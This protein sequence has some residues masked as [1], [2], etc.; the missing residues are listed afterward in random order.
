M[1]LSDNFR[2][3]SLILF[4]IS[5]LGSFS[6]TFAQTGAWIEQLVQPTM[7]GNW[8]A[9]RGENCLSYTKE[10]SQYIY[11]FDINISQWTEVNLGTP[12]AFHYLEVNGQTVLAYTDELIIGYSAITSNWDTLRYQG[13][14][15]YPTGGGY[16][17]GDRLAYFVT[18]SYFYVF[19]S[20]IGTWQSYGY[21]YPGASVSGN[22]WCGDDYVGVILNQ[23]PPNYCVIMVYSL[24]QH[25]FNENL[26]GGYYYHPSWK[27]S[28][29]FITTWNDAVPTWILTG[30][31]SLSNQFSQRI[32]LPPLGFGNFGGGFCNYPDNFVEKT[33]GVYIYL[34][35]ISEA[36]LLAYDT[37]QGSWFEAS[38]FFDPQYTNPMSNWHYGGRVAGSSHHN[39]QT[40]LNTYL[41]F[42]GAGGSFNTLSPGILYCGSISGSPIPAG[43]FIMAFDT[44]NVWF[45]NPANQ[46]SQFVGMPWKGVTGIYSGDNFAT[47]GSYD[48]PGAPAEMHF[49]NSTT[50]NITNI[51]IGNSS[52][53]TVT[54]SPYMCGFAAGV[55]YSEVYMYSGLLDA[56]THFSFP[57]NSYPGV[58]VKDQLAAA[59]TTSQ[60]YLY[61]AT[62][63]SSYS[64]SYALNSNT[65]GKDVAVF[66]KNDYA[67]DA[68]STMFQQL[69]EF[70]VPEGVYG[71]RAEGYI[72]LVYS[73]NY[74]Q[75]YAYNGFYNN[76][77]PLQPSGNWRGSMVGE[78]T[79]L[80]IR[81]DR[82]YAFDPQG[83]T[84]IDQ[85]IQTLNSFNLAQNYPNP[86]N[87]ITH[88]KYSLPRA[89]RVKIDIYNSL[90]QKLMILVDEYKKVGSY[91][92]E[93]NGSQFASGLYF[94]RIE[95]G[96]FSKVH[97]MIL[98]K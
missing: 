44:S 49:Y 14:L 15:L 1:A 78:N 28:H 32:I 41:L 51:S 27:M 65:I 60:S 80:V 92:V 95:A 74:G 73:S 9:D 46:S 93:F 20:E 17:C 45:Y 30:Y 89:S 58:Y 56:Y 90:G 72:G 12:Q 40:N 87:P 48:T 21:L 86:F 57:P 11:F 22:L 4:L 64:A 67:I 96:K 52:I 34:E 35:S 29:G 53:I 36:R 16:G 43:N 77:V 94:Y 76:M 23:N 97:K 3:L 42:D 25:A 69:T 2:K 50:D 5:F 84:G 13:T 26:Q 66:K 10:N 81:S 83:P 79:A 38:Y 37:Q 47:I 6:L 62:T 8:M 70:S 68:Y 75:F 18:D 7:S 54:G 71:I 63:N 19:D 33:V 98:M 39:N 85:D 55:G 24:P 59:V 61:D 91:S 82:I 31:S 88:I